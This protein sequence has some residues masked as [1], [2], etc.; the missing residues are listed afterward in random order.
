MTELQEFAKK[1]WGEIVKEKQLTDCREC[2]AVICGTGDRAWGRPPNRQDASLCECCEFV[3][4]AG[5]YS[6]E[7][8][9]RR[10]A[11]SLDTSASERR[12]KF[13]QVNAE[14]VQAG[15]EPMGWREFIEQ[16]N[17]FARMRRISQ[18]YRS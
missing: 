10:L 4:P 17:Y 14:R 5:N 9:D 12:V 18:G 3:E 15:H 13:A 1:P 6:Q 11:Y 2:K 7:L 16:E 8:R